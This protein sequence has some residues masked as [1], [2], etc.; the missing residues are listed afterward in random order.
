VTT[1]DAQN[2]ELFWALRGGGGN[3]GVVTAMTIRLH[4]VPQVL[5]GKI[6]FA[7]SEAMAVLTAFGEITASAKD[8]LAITVA[9]VCRS[10]GS[11]A[12]VVA[13]CWSGD[14]AQGEPVVAKLASLGSPA[15][16]T[17]A[18][19]PCRAHLV[20]SSPA[21]RLASATPSKRAGYRV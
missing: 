10:D 12:V 18:P 21:L 15:M 14:I 20:Y 19:M 9:L 13:P 2:P 16:T 4:P 17:I 5:A 6:M 11:P 7:W 1:N 8:A 3:F